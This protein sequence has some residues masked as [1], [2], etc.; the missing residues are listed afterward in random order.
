[1]KVQKKHLRR[2]WL[3]MYHGLRAHFEE[4]AS[5]HQGYDLVP[6]DQQSLAML[7]RVMQEPL[8]RGIAG[9]DELADA[10][11]RMDAQI[12]CPYFH[13]CPLDRCDGI[14][15]CRAFNLGGSHGV[16]VRSL[17]REEHAKRI[18]E[19]INE[20]RNSAGGRGEG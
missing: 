18:E 13:K 14:V 10:I 15:W 1:M 5:F 16:R 8:G 3:W 6:F 9:D 19:W 11:R 12:A 4:G 7:A 20:R 17:S 2:V